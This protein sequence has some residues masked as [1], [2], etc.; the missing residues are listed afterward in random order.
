[1]GTGMNQNRIF[2][3]NDFDGFNVQVM[4]LLMP[5]SCMLPGSQSCMGGRARDHDH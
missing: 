2:A 4:C 1:M 3:V 5:N